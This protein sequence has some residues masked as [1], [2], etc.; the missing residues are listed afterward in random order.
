MSLKDATRKIVIEDMF[1][2]LHNK[3][4]WKVLVVDDLG[5]K[6]I[7][8][9]LKM[10][11]MLDNGIT[12]IECLKK[13]RQPLTYLDAVYFVRP[14]QAN[15]DLIKKDFSDSSGSG[16]LYKAAH[17]FFTEII[18]DIML[19]DIAKSEIAPFVQTVKE[20]HVAFLPIEERVFSLDNPA[21]YQEFY[22]GRMT[23]KRLEEIAE[24]LVTVCATVEESPA[25]CPR[26]RICNSNLDC[27]KQ[28]AS[29]VQAKLDKYREADIL[30]SSNN[31][32]QLIILDRGFDPISPF[33]H[34]LTLQAMAYDLLSSA[35]RKINPEN[36]TYTV[37]ASKDNSEE[38]KKII[39]DSSK[40]IW[41]ELR[42]H[43]ISTVLQKVDQ[44]ARALHEKY[45]MMRD[46]GAGENNMHDMKALLNKIPKY[47]REEAKINSFLKLAE[48]CMAAYNSGTVE[49]AVKLEQD[50]STGVDSTGRPIGDKFMKACVPVFVPQN[51]GPLFTPYQKLRVLILY[52]LNKKDLNKHLTKDTLSRL[53]AKADIQNEEKAVNNLLSLGIDIFGSKELPDRR[54][55]RRRERDTSGVFETSR[56]TPVVLDIMEAVVHER[57]LDTAHYPYF[58]EDSQSNNDM[59]VGGITSLRGHGGMRQPVMGGRTSGPKLII[60]VMGSISYSEMR[61]AHQVSETQAALT[62][63][64]W[65][66]IIGSDNILTPE[67]YLDKLILLNDDPVQQP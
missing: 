13:Q 7:D 67:K 25:P 1:R 33:L 39:L 62:R 32:S 52:V 12:I 17:L 3:G 48:D 23:D 66:V 54:V 6:I 35:S 43:H 34:E 18:S 2:P 36:N 8:T 19:I 49:R 11:D 45:S 26:V 15:I 58:H 47:K 5:R 10:K 64:G 59:E 44:K 30:S 63:S 57:N 41:R 42:H 55:P 20:V 27:V 4:E 46:G 53:I 40:E 9:S 37:E 61:C 31:R 38:D 65:E 50:M 22:G 16:R 29:K 21:A 14:N 24:Q 60:Y 51:N 28:L 56:W